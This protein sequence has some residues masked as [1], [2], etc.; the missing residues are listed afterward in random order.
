MSQEYLPARLPSLIPKRGPVSSPN[1]TRYPV[2]AVLA[3]AVTALATWGLSFLL[4]VGWEAWPVVGAGIAA[5]A[6]WFV[7]SAVKYADQWEKAV[8]L[9]L[10]RYR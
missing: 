4:P 7:G 6:G 5:L 3:G 8:V 2:P 9:R 1:D 10:G